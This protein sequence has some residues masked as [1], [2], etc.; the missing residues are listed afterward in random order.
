[1]SVFSNSRK[2]V[3]PLHIRGFFTNLHNIS[4]MVMVAVLA[5]V[6]W[7]RWNGRPLV[8]FDVPARQWT[9]L[10]SMF[11][12]SE[13]I[14]LLL[15]LLMAAFGLFFFTA[16][17]GRLWCGYFCPQSV[18]MINM[19]MRVER[20][21]EGDRSKRMMTAKEGWNFDRAWRAAAKYTIFLGFAF[22][23]S[24]SFM[25]FFVR[26]EIL[27]AGLA[28]PTSYG[29]V[30]FFTGLWFFDF[31][32]FR[33]QTC[34]YVCPYARFQSALVDKQSL[35]ISYDALRGEPRG[36]AARERGGCIDCNKCVTVCPQGID[37]RNGFQL[38][39]IACGKCIDAC[40]S[41][42]PKLGYPTLV[43]YSTMAA[44]AGEPRRI[45]RPRTIAYGALLTALAAAI[46][47]NIGLHAPIELLVDRA[48][49]N[50]F[51]EDSDGF[52]R[53]TFM[54]HIADRTLAEGTQTFA[55]AVEGLPEN[56]QVRS[57]PI[58]VKAAERATVP[59]IVRVPRA[60]ADH[61]VPITFTVRGAEF[62]VSRETTFKGPGAV[63]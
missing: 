14:F 48:P 13:G 3:Y 61:T 40:E 6:P 16:V 39:C 44:D 23:V 50:L 28:G 1:M 22:L 45:L 34:N 51:I 60:A 54:V 25:G 5:V 38:E 55:V 4:S 58:Q 43:R 36:K 10:G 21:L 12:A 29:I 11:T 19:V 56:S 2:W 24:M 57:Q 17:F 27:W 53:N 33:E 35:I 8:L 49:G 47:V 30:A 41:V 63:E 7:L 42:M 26:T 20:W 31:A 32:W 15:F 9:V 37:I 52:V 62:S 59:V 46:V 18:F